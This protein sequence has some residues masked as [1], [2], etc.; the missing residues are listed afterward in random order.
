MVPL[1]S[2]LIVPSPWPSPIVAPLVAFDR[3]TVKVSFPS[4]LVSPLITIETVLVFSLA[5]NCSVL[6]FAA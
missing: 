5:A 2:L 4:A 1:S 3:L 6:E